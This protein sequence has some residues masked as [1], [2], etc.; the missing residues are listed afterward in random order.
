MSLGITVVYTLHDFSHGPDL[1][2]SVQPASFVTRP[3]GSFAGNAGSQ[4][5]FTAFLPVSVSL[6]S[7]PAACLVAQ[8]R[9]SFQIPLSLS[10]PHPLLKSSRSFIFALLSPL[11]VSLFLC[12]LSGHCQDLACLA[13][14]HSPFLLIHPSHCSVDTDFLH[15]SAPAGPL[16]KIFKWFLF[17]IKF[18]LAPQI[19]NLHHMNPELPKFPEVTALSFHPDRRYCFAENTL[20]F[21]G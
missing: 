10:P 8:V 11:T 5:E 6:Y 13:C 7:L 12:C 19:P 4:T 3:S 15:K 20:S 18:L 14:I 9:H 1:L 21:L 16:L 17:R 2:L